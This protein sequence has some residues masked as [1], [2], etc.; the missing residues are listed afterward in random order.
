LVGSKLDPTV[1]GRMS[2]FELGDEVLKLVMLFIMVMSSPEVGAN[3]GY[4]FFIASVYQK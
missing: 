2:F 3:V 4:L 1:I